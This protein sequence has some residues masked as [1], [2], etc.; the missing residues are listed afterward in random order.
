MKFFKIFLFSIILF[1]SCSPLTQ[2]ATATPIPTL[3]ATLKPTVTSTPTLVPTPTQI[4]GGSGNVIFS[5]SSEGYKDDFPELGG[6]Y[7]LFLS[8]FEGTNI[9]PIITSQL[10]RVEVEDTSPDGSKVLISS[11]K[12]SRKKDSNAKLYLFNLD[13][14]DSEPTFLARGFSRNSYNPSAIW[15]NNAEIVYIGNGDDGYGFYVID[16]NNFEARKLAPYTENP[17]EIL[18][19]NEE[20]VYWYTREKKNGG[21]IKVVWWTSL[22]GSDQGRLESNGLPV[23]YFA[24]EMDISPDGKMIAWL[25]IDPESECDTQEERDELRDIGKYRTTCT[26]FYAAYLSDMDNLMKIPLV[27]EDGKMPEDWVYFYIFKWAS[28]RSFL[29]IFNPG[30]FAPAYTYSIDFNQPDPKFVW[31]EDFPSARDDY[32]D[33]WYPTIRSF[34]P[35]G[36][37]LFI[38]KIIKGSEGKLIL[39]DVE[40][41]TLK[42]EILANLDYDE[43]YN[44]EF[45]P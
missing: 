19:V 29:Y 38:K 39:V 31:L 4:G 1:A 26:V 5:Y 15:I 33:G 6:K 34:S 24:D 7:N 45:L 20:R 22:D 25:P 18:A 41:M 2:T 12:Y 32:A 37:L 42:D 9:T 14:L 21:D 30:F 3:T 11:F 13:S 10:E 23:E 27:P 28:S 36:K 40:S 8:D 16:I 17:E 44:I 35:D 43:I